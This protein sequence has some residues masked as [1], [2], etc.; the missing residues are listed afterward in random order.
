M[1]YFDER[2]MVARAS[3]FRVG[4]PVLSEL[5]GFFPFEEI[6]AVVAGFGD[7]LRQLSRGE[8]ADLEYE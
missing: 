6:E 1:F 8:G 3:A 2:D 5:E 4:Q 7:Q